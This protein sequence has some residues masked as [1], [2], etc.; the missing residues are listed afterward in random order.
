MWLVTRGSP[1]RARMNREI[2]RR[3][4]VVGIFSIDA[5]AVRLSGGIHIEQNDESVVCRRY[6]SEGSMALMAPSEPALAR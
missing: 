5:S 2:G 1:S 6:L 3:V 4:D